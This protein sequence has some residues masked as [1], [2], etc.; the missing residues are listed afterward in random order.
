MRH[1]ALRIFLRHRHDGDDLRPGLNQVER[2]EAVGS[3]CEVNRAGGEQLHVV[4]PGTALADRDVEPGLFVETES[5][6]LVK[7][8][9]LR[10]R[11]PI[12]DEGDFRVGRRREPRLTYECRSA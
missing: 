1:Q 7:A 6:G 9:M 5:D 2:P 10:F 4:D 12:R 3:D 11:L 8:A